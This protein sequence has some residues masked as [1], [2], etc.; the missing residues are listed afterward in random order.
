MTGAQYLAQLQ[1]LLPQG[2]AWPR[3]RDATL[4]ALL[5]AWADE[6]AR[7]DLR[8][9]QIVD[10]DDVRSTFE[11]LADWERV[12]GLP[13]SC[14]GAGQTTQQRRA[15]LV[16][17][18]TSLGGQSRAYFIA[19]AAALGFAITIDEFRP[20]TVEDNCE[21]PLYNG[22]WAFSW[23]VNSALH[24]VKKFTVNDSV[25]DPIAFWSNVPLECVINRLKPAHTVVI[26]AY[27]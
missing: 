17:R 4:T 19:V 8:G 20:Y 2:G 1:A 7:V 18:V 6:L 26:F 27:S 21:K 11:L 23:R 13:D 12:A 15:A 16:Q 25:E 14:V 22:P 5:Q 9:D 3:D 10:E 24:T